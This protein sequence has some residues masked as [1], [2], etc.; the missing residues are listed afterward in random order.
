MLNTNFE[1]HKFK[2]NIA[3]KLKEWQVVKII[4]FISHIPSWR[5]GTNL[6]IETIHN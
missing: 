6:K 1:L 3:L 4:T 2:N 5:S